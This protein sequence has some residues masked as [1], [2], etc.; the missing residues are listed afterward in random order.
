MNVIQDNSE[1][2]AQLN[3]QLK[4][5]TSEGLGYS[6]RLSSAD[7]GA[8]HA[9]LIES[10]FSD[11]QFLNM[12]ETRAQSGTGTL[13]SVCANTVKEINLSLKKLK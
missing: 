10:G 9:L 2:L 5:R 1:Y 4:I 3:D 11:N 7:C 12:L 13:L 8:L 6:T